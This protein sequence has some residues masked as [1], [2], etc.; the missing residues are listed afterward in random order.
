M[1]P[2]QDWAAFL[3]SA[4]QHAHSLVAQAPLAWGHF[5]PAGSSP[6][7]M[8]PL[9]V[10]HAVQLSQSAIP[11][12]APFT[13]WL[14]TPLHGGVAKKRRAGGGD[15]GDNGTDPTA[16]SSAFPPA[17]K[18]PAAALSLAVA[19][20][21]A[22]TSPSASAQSATNVTSKKR[23]AAA[24][25]FPSA[26][27]RTILYS[28]NIDFGRSPSNYIHPPLPMTRVTSLMYSSN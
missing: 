10:H 1:T 8:A 14:T 25:G 7:R 27:R 4:Q 16:S 3:S 6:N 5:L 2:R 19:G 21:R 11:A 24:L 13:I 23:P 12:Q 17:K 20:R 18:R 22:T 28:R 9:E 15:D 26:P